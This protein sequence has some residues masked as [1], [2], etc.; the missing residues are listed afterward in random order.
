METRL[1]TGTHPRVRAPVKRNIC[2]A[3]SGQSEN[4]VILLFSAQDLDK[5]KA[6]AASPDL[7]ERMEK[8]GVPTSPD[9]YFLNSQ[10]D[11]LLFG[12]LVRQ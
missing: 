3:T 4:E 7:R 2:C 9:I 10:L 5:A 1:L 8:A 12:R 11:L 6:F